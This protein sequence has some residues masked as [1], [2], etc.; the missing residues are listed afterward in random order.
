MKIGSVSVWFLKI[1]LF[2]SW[3]I[4]GYFKYLSIE[5]KSGLS[6]IN[7]IKMISLKQETSPIDQSNM[8]NF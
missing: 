8:W 2:F 4:F 7:A 6:K 1:L 5:M 3:D